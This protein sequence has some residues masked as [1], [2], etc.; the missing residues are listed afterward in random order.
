M[1]CGKSHMKQRVK[2][3]VRFP[4]LQ[5]PLSLRISDFADRDRNEGAACLRAWAG[6]ADQLLLDSP[7]SE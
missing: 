3:L 6:T 7:R 2:L 1:S 5:D 4:L